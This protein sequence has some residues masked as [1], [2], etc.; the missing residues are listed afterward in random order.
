MTTFLCIIFSVGIYT[1]IVLASYHTNNPLH[2]RVPLDK[3]NV[4]DWPQQLPSTPTPSYEAFK[5]SPTLLPN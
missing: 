4:C 3:F 1:G 2:L 5:I